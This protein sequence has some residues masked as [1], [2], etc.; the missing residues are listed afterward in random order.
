[1]GSFLNQFENKDT[2]RN[3]AGKIND[4]GAQLQTN[5]PQTQPLVSD[6]AV[7]GVAWSAIQWQD[8][9]QGEGQVSFHIKVI[10]EEDASGNTPAAGVLARFFL[11]YGDTE[12]TDVTAVNAN[13]MREAAFDGASPQVFTAVN[14]RIISC[15]ANESGSAYETFDADA[16]RIGVAFQKTGAEDS[17]V[18][19]DTHII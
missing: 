7:T 15:L 6:L 11:A 18:N 19:C 17:V 16:I 5:D 12:E 13:A 4:R 8:L 2:G 10:G 14:D 9:S 1:M 3:F